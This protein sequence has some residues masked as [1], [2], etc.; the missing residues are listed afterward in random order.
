MKSG[1]WD[2]D[3]WCIRWWSKKGL[4]VISSNKWTGH[5]TCKTNKKKNLF[6]SLLF[7]VLAVI[8]QIV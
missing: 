6:D 1:F 3:C 5:T 2:L 4:A 8:Y 7:I